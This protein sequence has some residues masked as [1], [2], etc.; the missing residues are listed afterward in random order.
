[1]SPAPSPSPPTSGGRQAERSRPT[2]PT[3]VSAATCLPAH[4]LTDAQRDPLAL[5]ARQVSHPPT[6]TMIKPPS[7]ANWYQSHMPGAQTRLV[8]GVRP[9]ASC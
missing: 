9:C 1:M 5:P 6:A 2:W 8:C 7:C 4:S 3:T